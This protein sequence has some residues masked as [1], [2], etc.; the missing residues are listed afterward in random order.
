MLSG[1]FPSTQSHHPTIDSVLSWCCFYQWLYLLKTISALHFWMND[2]TKEAE[3]ICKQIVALDRLLCVCFTWLGWKYFILRLAFN[4]SLLH[5]FRHPHTHTWIV[6]SLPRLEIVLCTLSAALWKYVC[7][8]YS[9]HIELRDRSIIKANMS[10]R[11][12][13]ATNSCCIQYRT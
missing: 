5:L 10:K 4:L 1:V 11:G 3:W 13:D 9:C 12:R 6:S 7:F 8:H 2:S